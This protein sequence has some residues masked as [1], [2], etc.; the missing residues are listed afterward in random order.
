MNWLLLL[1]L[2]WS[3]KRTYSIDV[4]ELHAD[5]HFCLPPHHLE[6]HKSRKVDKTLMYATQ[7]PA[8]YTYTSELLYEK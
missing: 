7:I 2:L 4:P 6:H 1:L 3:A 8:T 5:S